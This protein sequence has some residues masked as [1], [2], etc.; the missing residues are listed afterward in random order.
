MSNRPR[1]S[2]AHCHPLRHQR[3][4]PASL[5]AVFRPPGPPTRSAMD[6][7]LRAGR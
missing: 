1:F 6:E 2:F 7:A 3:I 4:S 5:A